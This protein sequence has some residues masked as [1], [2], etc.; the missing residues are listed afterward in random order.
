MQ[1]TDIKKLRRF[2][3]IVGILTKY[4]FD[5]IVERLDLPEAD[6]LNKN[7]LID[8][9]L[10]LFERIRI[11]L[12]ELGLTFVKFGQMMS[13]RLD[14]LHSKLLFELEKQQ[15]RGDFEK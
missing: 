4:G 12:E 15:D 9:S 8:N 14:L 1:L 6:F 13:I 10:T 2:K 3:N 5:E 7:R 11:I